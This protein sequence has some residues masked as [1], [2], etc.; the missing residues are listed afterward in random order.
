MLISDGG[1]NLGYTSK[2]VIASAAF[3][4]DEHG[5]Y[6]IGVG[7]G[8]TFEY[9]DDL[10]DAATDAGRGAYVFIDR[11]EEAVRQ[12]SDGFL[13]NFIV[14]ARNVEMKVTL[15]WYFGVKAFHGEEIAGSPSIVRPQHR[16]PNDVMAFHPIIRACDASFITECDAVTVELTY[17]EAGSGRV[18]TDEI[19]MPLSNA[20]AGDGDHLYKAEAIVGYAKALIVIAW[21]FEHGDREGAFDVADNMVDWLLLAARQLDDPEVMEVAGLMQRYAS[22]LHSLM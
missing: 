16:A 3:G 18:I 11:E 10:M 21:L 13:S 19:V 6:L 7:V 15:P 22:T 1:A 12:F 8:D 17:S 4:G 9:R 20:V 14:A 2:N 5:V